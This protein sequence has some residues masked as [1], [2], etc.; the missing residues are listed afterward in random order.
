MREGDHWFDQFAGWRAEIWRIWK[1][2]RPQESIVVILGIA[3]LAA[4]T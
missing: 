4:A 2:I 3:L 1:S